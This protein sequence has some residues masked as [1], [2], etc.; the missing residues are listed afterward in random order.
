[1][2]TIVDQ[3]IQLLL[4]QNI[5]ISQLWNTILCSEH[6]CSH[7]IVNCNV[8]EMVIITSFSLHFTTKR[9]AWPNSYEGLDIK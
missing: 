4:I 9:Y 6:S 3:E 8:D 1:M 2:C 7:Y 5:D